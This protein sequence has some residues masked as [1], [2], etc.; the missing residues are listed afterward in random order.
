M[1]VFVQ[2]PNSK[3]SAKLTKTLLFC[4]VLAGPLFL[5]ITFLQIMIRPGF[6]VI[7]SE[8]SLLSLGSLGWIQIANCVIAGLL[9]IAGTAGIRRTLA[10]NKGRFWGPLLLGIFGLG[11][12]G[13]GVFVVDPIGSPA[14]LSFHG[15]MHLVLGAIGF[16]ALMSACFVL[17]GTFASLKRK[18]WA[19]FSA[20]T[21]VIFLA[22]FFGAAAVNQRGSSIQFFLN[23]VIILEWIWVSLVSKQLMTVSSIPGVMSQNARM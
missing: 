4:G 22:T 15:T 11:Q 19:V 18:R 2:A 6:D 20:L 16:V 3:D 13:V 23:L 21:G 8:P 9:V 17:V 14:R 10:F 12:I 1:T 7:R 5:L